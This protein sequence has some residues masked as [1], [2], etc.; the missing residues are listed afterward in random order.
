MERAERIYKNP[1]SRVIQSPSKQSNAY[2]QGFKACPV[3]QNWMKQVVQR[4][5]VGGAYAETYKNDAHHMPSARALAA[6]VVANQQKKAGWPVSPNVS[7]YHTLA[8]GDIY[9]GAPA[10][11]MEHDK[12][13]QTRTYGGKSSTALAADLPTIASKSAADAF[14]DIQNKDIADCKSC[15]TNSNTLTGLG[16]I[17]TATSTTITQ[18]QSAIDAGAD[19]MA[20][21]RSGDKTSVPV[22]DVWDDLN[23]LYIHF[24]GNASE[25]ARQIES[26][27]G[28]QA[29][30]SQQIGNILRRKVEHVH[31]STS[32]AIR[33]TFEHCI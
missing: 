2:V 9:R 33:Q 3:I 11:W 17:G 27:M 20:K 29:L 8:V 10:V 16:L 31:K 12:H 13:A 21:A 4:E 30:T 14:K 18:I 7:V 26:F 28:F 23:K 32:D 22:G 24:R 25:I 15:T 1:V 19:V 6:I 5:V